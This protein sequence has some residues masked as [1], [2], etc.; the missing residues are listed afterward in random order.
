MLNLKQKMK[1][2]K[3]L[4]L[5]ANETNIIFWSVWKFIYYLS[6]DNVWR[7]RNLLLLLLRGATELS[8]RGPGKVGEQQYCHAVVKPR[9]GAGIGATFARLLRTFCSNQCGPCSAPRRRQ[10]NFS[11][12]IWSKAEPANRPFI[13]GRASQ[14]LNVHWLEGIGSDDLNQLDR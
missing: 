10:E 12:P 6:E 14:R 1:Y 4:G 5:Q 2:A 13:R 3:T 9:L 11:F 8:C 7:F